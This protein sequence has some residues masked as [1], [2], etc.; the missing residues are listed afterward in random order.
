MNLELIRVVHHRITPAKSNQ[1]FMWKT[2][3]GF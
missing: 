3:K 2:V 1:Q